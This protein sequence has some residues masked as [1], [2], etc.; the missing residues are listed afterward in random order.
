[1]SVTSS[2][3]I[4]QDREVQS[5]DPLPDNLLVISISKR[6]GTPLDASSISEE[7]VVEL[8]VGRAHTCPLGVLRYSMADSVVFLSSAADVSRTQRALLEVTAFGDESIAIRTVAPTE[9]QITAFQVMWHSNPAVGTR[10]PHTPPYHT[11][12][13]EE[14]PR[15]IH[16]QLG[17]LNDQELRQ[18][19]RDLSQEIAQ[20]K[21]TEPPSY[22][23]PRDWACPSGNV[24]PGED[25]REVTFLR[26]GRVPTGPQPPPTSPAP[27][28]PDMGQLISAL[29][30]GLRIG[31]PKISTFS[32][33]VAPGKTEVSYE[34][35]SHEVQC[36]KDHYPESVVCESIMQS[37][38][39][40]VADMAHYM[41]PTASVSDILE[42]LSVIFGTVTSFDVLMQNFYK[43][44]QGNEKVPSF[45]TRL[46]GTLNQ[47]RI[48]CPG[49]IADHE[50]PSHLK[51]RLFH[52]VKKHV[53]DSVRYLYSNLRTTYPELVVAARRAESK[54]EETKVKAQSAAATEVPTG[55]KELGD[56]I[57]RLMAALTRAEQS[58]CSASAPS[59]P[60]HRGR[61]RGR[62]DRQTSVCPN[63]HN[64]WTGLGQM[65]A[66]S[67]SVMKSSVESPRQGNQNVQTGRQSNLQGA[68]G[69]S[70]LQ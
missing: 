29:T 46:E 36:V 19:V 63:S 65:S 27:A 57:A 52:S 64:G 24:V 62:T 21:S 51:D 15:R 8:C 20:C 12:P 43:I 13:N 49:R 10:E 48:K 56:Q 16:A 70:L 1:M 32:G 14:T 68:R 2:A 5:P 34:Q 17:D 38:K 11:P 23:P 53:R 59:S 18:L 6:D 4:S 54:T 7:D 3:T 42:K 25:D 39:G 40:A 45:A 58:T 28:G 26:G 30:S 50:V 66:R 69:S 41:G 60:R 9:V 35:W 67:S 55:S 44:A 31:T 61:G 22:P 47:I 37:L 33:E